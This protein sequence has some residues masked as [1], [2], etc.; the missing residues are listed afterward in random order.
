MNSLK[1]SNNWRRMLSFGGYAASQY[2]IYTPAEYIAINASKIPTVISEF[3]GS[4]WNEYDFDFDT[5]SY[6]LW[7]VDDSQ[8]IHKLAAKLNEDFPGCAKVV[9]KT[10]AEAH[11]LSTDDEDD[12]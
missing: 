1:F 12:Y 5:Y 7:H 2:D 9:V 8:D 6:L 3:C 4:K 11:G 10:A